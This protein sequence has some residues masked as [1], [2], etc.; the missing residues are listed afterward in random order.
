MI[1]AIG[2]DLVE[3]ARI[4]RA[5]Q[6]FGHRFSHRLF[7]DGE[8]AFCEGKKHRH[9]QWESYACRF[10]AKEACFKALYSGTWTS[11]HRPKT[12]RATLPL[13]HDPPAPARPTG[14]GWRHMEVVRENHSPP[15]LTLHDRAEYYLR[16]MTPTGYHP[17]IHLSLSGERCHAQAMVVIGATKTRAR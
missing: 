5:M 4:T 10:A 11:P 2:C 17:F 15:R 9:R 1:I 13:A 14:I 7:T 12:T 8:R 16:R 6:R 3:V